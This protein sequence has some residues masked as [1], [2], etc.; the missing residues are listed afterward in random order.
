MKTM[1][2]K[3]DEFEQ[4]VVAWLRGSGWV[5]P[6]SVTY[7]D[8]FEP[9]M[10]RALA[11]RFDATSLSIRGQADRVA[12]LQ[13][14]EQSVRV[15][16]KTVGERHRNLAVELFAFAEHMVRARMG[17]ECVYTVRHDDGR[18]YGFRVGP[19][20]LDAVAAVLVP[21]RWTDDQLSGLIEVTTPALAS[22]LRQEPIKYVR[23]PD[24]LRG[25]GD[26]FVLI[27]SDRLDRFDD[28]PDVFREL[29]TT[30]GGLKHATN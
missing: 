9:H 25:S 4:E 17:C 1:N 5:V 27:P 13:G 7:H 12:F 16:I 23:A 22:A 30:A 11:A 28:W 29:E 24:P 21:Y 20:I 8:V 15:E 3:H 14:A 19:D 2:N 6:P 18:E 26:P 10:A